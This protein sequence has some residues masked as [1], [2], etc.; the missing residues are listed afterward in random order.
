MDIDNLQSATLVCQQHLR[1]RRHETLRLLSGHCEKIV[2]PVEK[3]ITIVTIFTQHRVSTKIPISIFQSLVAHSSLFF[4]F[5][6]SFLKAIEH[7]P[8][9]CHAGQGW[10]EEESSGGQV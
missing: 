7:F 8:K 5:T 1:D 6:N 10:T 4:H 9:K 2:L 3:S